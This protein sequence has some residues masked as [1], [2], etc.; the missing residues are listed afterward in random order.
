MTFLKG[1]LALSLSLI[2]SAC[3]GG[4]G[5]GYFGKEN[6]SSDNNSNTTDPDKV[7]AQSTLDSLKKEGQYL[8]GNYDPN[9][10][11]TAKGYIDHSLDTFAQG[12]LQLAVD[13]KKLFDKDR[14][15]FTYSPVCFAG[16]GNQLYENTPCYILAGEDNIKAALNTIAPNTYTNW[17]FNVT[18]EQLANLK[19][20]PE[21]LETF[22]GE[23]MLIIFDNQNK[24]KAFNDIWVTGVFAYPYAQSWGLT[25][26]NQL[27][28]VAM[29]G[30]GEYKITS[31]STVINSEGQPEEVEKTYGALSVYKYP[32]STDGQLFV[33]QNNSMVDI[34]TNDNPNT[35]N[36]EPVSFTINSIPG[37]ATALAT[38]RIKA[39]GE[40]VLNL[41]SITA[42]SGTR[43]ENEAPSSNT[44]SF[45]GSVH[46]EGN[47][48]FT[49]KK[50]MN[51]TILKF[52]HVFNGITFEGQSTNSNGTVN[53]ILTQPSNLK[54]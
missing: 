43:I 8:F 53:T 44:Q 25:Q 10:A 27:R 1:T 39:S 49:F 13:A 42:L 47:N 7:L 2:L 24:D 54:Y 50:A 46:L 48:I 33:L 21:Q 22:T 31:K 9:D 14:S 18:K 17:D 51:G 4:G 23:S 29:N 15:A 32:T 19:I 30:D 11:T 41:P 28:I 12:P 6:G 16:E 26:N 3:G 5:D 45:T 20:T 36:L 35:P 40:Q 52:K 38:Y 34:L 37:D